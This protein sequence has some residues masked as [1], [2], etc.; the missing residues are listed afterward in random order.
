MKP[1]VETSLKHCRHCRREVVAERPGRSG[2]LLLSLLA[3]AVLFPGWYVPRLI[4]SPGVMLAIAAVW[5]P[6]WSAI[7]LL[8]G[9]SPWKCPA[10]HSRL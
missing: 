5:F 6:A 4:E 3:C 7:A 8:G 10:C 1:A 2:H 9:R